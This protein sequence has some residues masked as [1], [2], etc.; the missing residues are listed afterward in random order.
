MKSDGYRPREAMIQKVGKHWV[1]FSTSGKVL[2]TH[3]TKHE[4]VSQERAIQIAKAR[5]AGHRIPRPA[6]KR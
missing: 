3:R 6:R 1:L 4:A 5:R 2:G